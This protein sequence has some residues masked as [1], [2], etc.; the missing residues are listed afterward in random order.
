M[1]EQRAADTT[2]RRTAI[3][4][5]GGSGIGLAI[6]Q[7]LAADGM[8]VALFDRDADN[9]AAAADDINDAGGT[10]LAVTVDVSDR[11]QIDAGVAETAEALGAATV[12]VNSAGVDGFKPFLKIT[13]EV[14]DRIIAVNLTGTFDCCQ[15]VVPAMIDAGWGRIINIGSSSAEGG[16]PLMTHYV[17]SKGGVIGLTKSLALEFGPKGITANVVSPGFIDSP[18]LRAT[19]AKGRLGDTIEFHASKTPVRRVG[20]PEDIAG[21]CAYLASDES[22][23][24]TGQVMGVNGGRN[25]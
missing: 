5:G 13:R 2:P 6:A 25:T 10:A 3:V 21:M 20:Q 1:S 4:T 18:M 7:R 9:A 23:Y 14:W 17:S 16:Q 24:V 12:L 15:A 11:A 19:E 8:A 22:S